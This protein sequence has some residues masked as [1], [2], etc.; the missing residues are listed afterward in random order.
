MIMTVTK[1]TFGKT[2]ACQK[3]EHTLTG[4]KKFR[5]VHHGHFARIRAR[6]GVCRLGT[7]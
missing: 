5:L 7:R 1:T 3:Y 6:T 2:T 4:Q